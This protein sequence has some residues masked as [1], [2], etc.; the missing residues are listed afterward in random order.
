MRDYQ[1]FIYILI[2]NWRIDMVKKCFFCVS[3]NV[4]RNG[5]RGR[6]QLYEC[7]CCGKQF[8]GGQRRDES[9]VT[10]DYVDGRQTLHQLAVKYGVNEK[11][12]RRGLEGMRYVRKISKYKDV[13]IRMDTA[14]RGWNFGLMVIR[15]AVRG[16]ALWHKYVHHETVAQYIEGVYWLKGQGFKIYGAVTDGMKGLPK[17]L[18]PVPVQMC[19]FHQMLIARRY[20]TE[21]PG[22]EASRKL[23]DLVNM[24]TKTDKE[25]FIGAFNDWYGNYK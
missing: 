14:C 19:Q 7:K 20:L 6:K 10:E 17:A 8:L 1:L 5:V 13:T 25:S 2:P 21:N 4:V 18:R 9:Q 23:P 22:I 16:K 24:I 3:P 15:D 11:T 12:I